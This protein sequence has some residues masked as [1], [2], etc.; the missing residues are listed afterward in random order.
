MFLDL[1]NDGALYCTLKLWIED[2]ERHL[3]ELVW[4]G[5]VVVH[6]QRLNPHATRGPHL[7]PCLSFLP[8]VHLCQPNKQHF[9][10]N[11]TQ[12]TISLSV[13]LPCCSRRVVSISTFS[14]LSSKVIVSVFFQTGWQKW[15]RRHWST[16]WPEPHWW[17]ES[18]VAGRTSSAVGPISTCHLREQ[19][20][21]EWDRTGPG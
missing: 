12:E 20:R 19:Q 1:R 10:L 6:C 3:T 18:S 7:A 5:D 15:R 8:S 11:Q 4:N 13:M 17:P 16:R 9:R 21:R 2:G 14:W